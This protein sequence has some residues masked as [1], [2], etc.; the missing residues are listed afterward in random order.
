MN[1][2]VDPIALLA[3]LG[4]PEQAAAEVDHG[5]SYEVPMVP[6]L[7]ARLMRMQIAGT[8]RQPICVMFD[9]QTKTTFPLPKD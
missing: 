6:P 9:P 4:K 5:V 2:L 1:K 3:Q 8:Y 7:G